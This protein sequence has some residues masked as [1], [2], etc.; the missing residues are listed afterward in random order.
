MTQ[1]LRDELYSQEVVSP[2]KFKFDESVANVF[3]DMIKRSVPGYGMTLSLM[4]L[5]ARRYGQ[6]NSK[7]YDL[8]C[9]LG[10]GM[11]ALHAGLLKETKII[12]VDN[13]QSMLDRCRQ[14]LDQSMPKATFE[15]LHEDILETAISD[16]SLVVMNFTLQFIAKEKR[17]SLLRRICDGILPG[18]VFLLSEKI[19]FSD[20]CI[21]SEMMKLHHDFKKSQGYSELEISQ[22][23]DALE[24]VL[25]PESIET[26]KQRLAEA[27][28][29]R[30]ET[31]LQCFNFV[32]LI[33]F[34]D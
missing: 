11:L 21:Q 19:E 16:A 23:R 32:S 7:I 13:S 22:K 10:A 3:E 9:S 4:P 25:L 18:G 1:S 33:A 34:K 15:L 30:S 26:H 14:N 12:G 8:G 17:S 5:I 24:N 28:F 20:Q 29:A 6:E 31:W 27:G 2:E